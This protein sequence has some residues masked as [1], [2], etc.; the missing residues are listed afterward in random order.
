M[1]RFKAT[2]RD[3][4][5]RPVVDRR[6]RLFQKLKHT[7]SYN[8]RVKFNKTKAKIKRMY[9]AKKRVS[10]LE[11][12]SKIDARTN[13]FKLWTFAKSLSR[14]RPQLEVC[15]TILTAEG[16]PPNDD[17]VIVNTL[18]SHYQKMRR[19]TLNKVDK[20]TEIQLVFAQVS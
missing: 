8:I 15:Y 11:I 5:L 13:N 16:F 7:N 18:G 1:Q 4:C 12:W 9:A 3:P 14:D 2:Y 17:R 20:Q 6:D 19:L 10:R